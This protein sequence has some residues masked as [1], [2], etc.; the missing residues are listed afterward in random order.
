MIDTTVLTERVMLSKE[1]LE[2]LASIPQHVMVR[3]HLIRFGSITVKEAE[4]YYGITRLSDVI[5]KLRYKVE[6]HMLIRTEM[7]KGKNR[8]GGTVDY[9]KYYLMED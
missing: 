5:Y 7:H 9:G 2:T 1:D 8:F 4:D 6:P 3:N